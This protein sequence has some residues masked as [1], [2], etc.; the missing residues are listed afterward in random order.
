MKERLDALERTATIAALAKDAGLSDAA[1]AAAMYP[2][3]AE[4]TPE[5]VKAW[6][7]GLRAAI[8][9]AHRRRWWGRR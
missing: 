5:A 7:D 6:A 2:K 1:A 4:A 8:A 3:D 9:P